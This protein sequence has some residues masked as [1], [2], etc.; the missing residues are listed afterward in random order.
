LVG[1]H[2]RA[3]HSGTAARPALPVGPGRHFRRWASSSPSCPAGPHLPLDLHHLASTPARKPLAQQPTP[4]TT[5]HLPPA[6][7]ARRRL[8]TAHLASAQAGPLPGPTRAATSSPPRPSAPA[9][10]SFHPR[11]LRHHPATAAPPLAQLHHQRLLAAG[12][13]PRPRAPCPWL[14]LPPR[15]C[16]TSDRPATTARPNTTAAAAVHHQ[17]RLSSIPTAIHAKFPQPAVPLA[18]HRQCRSSHPGSAAQ[19]TPAVPPKAPRQCR[20]CPVSVSPNSDSSF[21]SKF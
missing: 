4:P 10:P 11:A 15:T 6:S 12:A 1:R 16:S 3:V 5:G 13:A 18:P 21:C 8:A 14:R 17:Q 19:S 9:T 2:C 20:L 7:T